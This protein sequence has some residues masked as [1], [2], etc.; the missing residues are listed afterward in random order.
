MPFFHHTVPQLFCLALVCAACSSSESTTHAPKSYGWYFEDQ[1]FEAELQNETYRSKGSAAADFDGDGHTDLYVVNP[2]EGSILYLNNGDG[3]FRQQPTAPNVG[4]DSGAAVAD[5]DNDGDPDLY[6]PCGSRTEACKDGLFRNDGTEAE[7]GWVTFTDVTDESGLGDII[8]ANLGGAWA[9]YDLDGDLDLFT[10]SVE[11]VKSPDTPQRDLLY[12]NKGDGTFEEV[13]VEAGITQE[14]VSRNGVWFDANNDGYP[15]LYIPGFY[16][17]NRLYMNLG[18]GTFKNTLDPTLIEEPHRGAAAVA[19]DFNNDGFLDLFVLGYTDYTVTFAGHEPDQ[20]ERDYPFKL[21]LNDGEG[22]FVLTQG[23]GLD[24][25]AADFQD[26]RYNP[27][28][29]VCADFDKDGFLDLFV[30]DEHDENFIFSVIR[31]HD[32][33]KLAW[34]DRSLVIR[35][36]SWLEDT[37]VADMPRYPYYSHTTTTFDFDGDDDLD[38]FIGNGGMLYEPQAAQPNRLFRN[39]F[40]LEQQENNWLKL[41]LIGVNS[42][43]DAI[44]ARVRIAD[45]S[46]E[47]ASWVIH[48]HVYRNH[49]SNASRPLSLFVGLGLHEGPYALD[50]QFPNGKELSVEGIEMNQLHTFT[51]PE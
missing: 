1:A 14:S 27:N 18:D 36:K 44:G 24:E 40:A 2:Y 6:V 42:N 21:F 28:T 26:H 10:A 29:L 17:P 35:K 37:R 33:G 16:A 3:T 47:D 25:I 9:D 51:E 20:A 15:D 30:S 19:E 7:S 11:P 41:K 12:R 13:G 4:L 8:Q 49:G 32:T 43:K 39:D 31:D 50:I 45:A 22:G 48:R 34:I 38:I 5:Y 46:G 23:G